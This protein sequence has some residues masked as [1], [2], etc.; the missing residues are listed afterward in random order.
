MHNI[1]V[2]QA[3]QDFVELSGLVREYVVWCKA[4]YRDDAWF[5]D[6]AF[7]HQAL[8]RELKELANNH[9]P[10]NGKA[11]LVRS[12]EETCACGVYKKWHEGTCE[13]KRLF[14]LDRFRGQGTGNVTPPP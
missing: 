1:I 14:V 4:R 7:S 10:P 2:A 3:A 6:Q 5:I 8:D 11:L 13:M 9:T 12:R